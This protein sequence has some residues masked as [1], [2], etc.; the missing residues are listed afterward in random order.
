M[1]LNGIELNDPLYNGSMLLFRLFFP[2]KFDI[3]SSQEVLLNVN[4]LNV[5]PDAFAFQLSIILS[6]YSDTK[7]I[8]NTFPVFFSELPLPPCSSGYR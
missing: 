7:N 6:L 3:M 2:P 8:V 5:L 1:P 4:S